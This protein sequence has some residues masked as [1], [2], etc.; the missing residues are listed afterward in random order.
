LYQEG[1]YVKTKVQRFLKANPSPTADELD[2]VNPLY[3]EVDRVL[4][5]RPLPVWV[6]VHLCC[7][8]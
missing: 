4:A 8:C 5:C 2:I 7:C 6:S 1:Q 3:L